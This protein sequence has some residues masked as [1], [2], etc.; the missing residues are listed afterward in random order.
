MGIN[1]VVEWGVTM[2]AVL[3]IP[4]IIFIIFMPVTISITYF[5]RG[6]D[7]DFIVDIYLFFKFLDL[8]IRI[9]YLQNSFFRFFSEVFGEI[10]LVFRKITVWKEPV[11]LE[12]EV[13][14]KN[15]ELERLKKLFKLILDKRMINIISRNLNLRCGE[16][17]WETDIGWVNPAL[18]G[19]SSGFIWSLKGILLAVI[20]NKICSLEK[21]KVEIDVNP[22]FYHQVFNTHF[23]GIF[24]V[25]T[26]NIILTV[27]KVF[28]Y[29]IKG[30]YKLWENIRL[31]N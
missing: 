4:L 10:D 18:T 23:R 3:L 5:R 8:K 15:I 22:D 27:F 14:W 13:E 19:L 2:Y 29:K 24:S 9:P 20:D 12:K 6:E 31:K 7:D 26:G 1:K 16:L 11:E 30:G 25:F 21:E 17:T 28:L